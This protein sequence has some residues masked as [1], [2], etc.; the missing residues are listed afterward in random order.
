[1]NRFPVN[2]SHHLSYRASSSLTSLQDEKDDTNALQTTVVGVIFAS[3][4]ASKLK[5]KQLAKSKEK[6]LKAGL[7]TILHHDKKEEVAVHTVDRS[8]EIIDVKE[9]WSKYECNRSTNNRENNIFPW[10]AGNSPKGSMTGTG[11][12]YT[13]VNQNILNKLGGSI[14]T[15]KCAARLK[16]YDIGDDLLQSVNAGSIDSSRS[17][18]TVGSITAS[19]TVSLVEELVITEK[20]GVSENNIDFTATCS[21]S[22]STTS[23]NNDNSSDKILLDLQVL[24][25][26]GYISNIKCNKHY[27]PNPP[28]VNTIGDKG[29]NQLVEVAFPSDQSS[30]PDSMIPLCKY[31]L[32]QYRPNII[33]VKTNLVFDSNNNANLSIH[34]LFH[35]SMKII[36]NICV[37]A[38]LAAMALESESVRCQSAGVYSDKTKF[39]MWTAKSYENIGKNITLV[40]SFGVDKSIDRSKLPSTIPVKINGVVNDTAVTSTSVSVSNI[41]VS[42]DK[43]IENKVNAITYCTKFE[44]KCL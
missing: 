9:I 33:K 36:S 27:S 17:A 23:T 37:L 43:N 31:S 18:I 41:R 38:S 32:H 5:E 4:A 7:T 30:K 20:C 28:T 12:N 10:L 14:V 1:M 39:I 42:S 15:D 19:V 34:L 29:T 25:E 44:Y 24:N 21:A 26:H 3:K 13:R 16:S 8:H 22:V 6:D 2:Q 11:I 35:P 40:A